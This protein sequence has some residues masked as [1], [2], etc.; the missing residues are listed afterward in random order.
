[1]FY[2]SGGVH[3][4]YSPDNG[5]LK[6]ASLLW[7]ENEATLAGLRLQNSSAEWFIGDLRNRA[8][9][10]SLKF[11][12]PWWILELFH[13]GQGRS[14]YTGQQIHA[15]V[16]FHNIK[17]YEPKASFLTDSQRVPVPWQ[18][19]F[20]LSETGFR[21]GSMDWHQRIEMDLFDTTFVSTLMT[22]LTELS[23]ARAYRALKRL[24]FVASIP[25]G[26]LA[27][28]KVPQVVNTL[29]V[30]LRSCILGF[31]FQVSHLDPHAVVN[32]QI[33]LATVELL[34]KLASAYSGADELAVVNPELVVLVDLKTFA[35]WKLRLNLVWETLACFSR[36][37]A[38][39]YQLERLQDFTLHKH[40]SKTII[41]LAS[42]DLFPPKL[43]FQDFMK[44]L[45]TLLGTRICRESAANALTA[46]R[47]PYR[48][49]PKVM[50]RTG[51]DRLIEML[52]APEEEAA[53]AASALIVLSEPFKDRTTAKTNFEFVRQ[54]IIDSPQYK[55]RIK[56]RGTSTSK[57]D[58]VLDTLDNCFINSGNQTDHL[59]ILDRVQR[60][61]KLSKIPLLYMSATSRLAGLASDSA[62][63]KAMI[64]NEVEKALILDLAMK[65]PHAAVRTLLVLLEH[66]DTRKAVIGRMGDLFAKTRGICPEPAGCIL[67]S[68]ARYDDA[69]PGFRRC[70][71]SL[72]E[73]L[74]SATA[75]LAATLIVKLVQYDD[76]RADIVDDIYIDKLIG[77]LMRNDRPGEALEV[78]RYLLSEHDEILGFHELSASIARRFLPT[79][80]AYEQKTNSCAATRAE[81]YNGYFKVFESS[82]VRENLIQ[83][84][85]MT[86]LVAT[87]QKSSADLDF[88][89]RCFEILL[90]YSNGRQAITQLNMLSI[91][92]SMPISIKITALS[93]HIQ[94][95][96][97][98]PAVLPA[99]APPDDDVCN[100]LWDED[101]FPSQGSH[102]SYYSALS[103]GEKGAEGRR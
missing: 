71:G 97:A 19:L 65:E 67:L 74:S 6:N 5:E 91:L 46:L 8:H 40:W 64:R 100:G 26:Q 53:A 27:I 54:K 79:L 1:M 17:V 30:W 4:L 3:S 85:C 34:A 9:E 95:A 62:Q 25:G 92:D 77:S 93:K 103:W 14:I 82:E 16:A 13:R 88:A 45:L 72:I 12:P 50:G 89:T 20:S 60:L 49:I 37:L 59:D 84:S 23:G 75:A 41:T 31:P 90:E 48:A 86:Y 39:L 99:C 44:G 78:L 47:V 101:D 83:Q 76:F 55:S 42:Y 28:A 11:W 56:R 52:T 68:I 69:A 22:E 51:V 96:D 29:D 21:L 87:L 58:D 24:A 81:N 43:V 73:M 7:M 70:I 57:R 2:P 33:F 10:K 35:L 61:S 80:N 36:T 32:S 94:E 18:E 98:Q 66:E 102:G 38:D 63:R 15:S